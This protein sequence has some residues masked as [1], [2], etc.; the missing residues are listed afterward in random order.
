MALCRLSARAAPRGGAMRRRVEPLDLLPPASRIVLLIHG[1]N[2]TQASAAISYDDFLA[3]S[4]I[5][6]S[7]RFPVVCPF[8][9]PGDKSWGPAAGL[10]Y[11]LEIKPAREAG[12]LLAAFL[13]TFPVPGGWPLDVYVVCHSLGSRVALEL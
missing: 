11:P 1:Y 2:N 5:E 13:D 3:K 9:W 10:S 8:F 6:S 12:A 7:G 4:G